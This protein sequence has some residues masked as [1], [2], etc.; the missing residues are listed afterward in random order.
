MTLKSPPPSRLWRAAALY[1]LCVFAVGM[2]LGPPRVLWLEPWLGK[3]LAVAIE[4]PFLI[5]A[6]WIF[7]DLAPRWAGFEGGGAARLG[8]GLIALALQQ[9]ADL[10]VGFGLRGMTLQDQLVYFATPAGGIY[11]LTLVT[12]ALMPWIR[13]AA[14]ERR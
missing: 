12:F 2:L 11:A 9:V 8:V 6:I 5:F 13:V 14:R 4:A 10:A 1:F 7:A 3:T